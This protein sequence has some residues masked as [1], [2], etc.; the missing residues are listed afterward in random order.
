MTD[1][2]RF[3]LVCE[4]FEQV[5]A[6]DSDQQQQRRAAELCL[7]DEDLLAQVQQMLDA[8]RGS[9]PLDQPSHLLPLDALISTAHEHA[10]V[11]DRYIIGD[12]IGEGGMGVVYAAE[13]KSPARAVAI[14]V[15]KLG[16]DSERVIARF[17]L[18]RQALARMEHPNIASVVDAG[19]TDDGRPYFAMEL[20]RGETVTTYAAE[21]GL[22]T[23][24][25]L[26]LVIMVCNAIQHAHQKGIIHRDIKPSNIIVTQSDGS[27]I[28]KVIDF[29]IAKATQGD[30]SPEVSMTLHAQALGTPAYM[31]PEQ[32]DPSVG[33]ID[34]RTDV[35]SLGVVLYELLT[36]TTP[37]CRD[38]LTSKSY[39]ELVQSIREQDPPRPSNR[40]ATANQGNAS[41]MTKID[42]SELKGDLDWI[43]M[44]CLEKEPGRRYETIS[45]LGEDI[46]RYLRNKPVLARP[47]SSA[48]VVRKF[49]RR[50]RGGVVAASLILGTMLIG[51]AG[52]TVS[53]VWALDEQERAK[54]SAQAEL[55]AQTEAKEAAEVALSEAK[56]AEDLSQFFIMDVLSAADPSKTADR[57][58]TVR[59]ALVNASDNLE[60]KFEERPDVEGR[61]HNALGFLFGQ[62]GDPELAQ[63]HHMREWEI[64][65]A[66]NGEF[67]IES[68]RMMH[69][70]VGSLARQG[71]DSEAIEL[72]QRQLRVIDMLGTEEAELLRPRAIGNLGALLVRTG[73]NEEAAPILVDTLEIKRELY[74][75]RHPTTLSTLNNL[76]SVLASIGETEQSMLY[77]REAYE[78]RKQ[79]LGE[80]DPRTFVSLL[81]LARAIADSEMYDEALL[82]LQEGVSD[83]TKRLGADHPTTM[84]IINTYAKTLLDRGDYELSEQ[85][86][87]ANL[88]HL[89][90]ADPELNHARTMTAYTTLASTLRNQ[91]RP[92][93]ALA[94]TTTL[95]STLNE[96]GR[97]SY[98]LMSDFFRL[99]GQ[100]LMDLELFDQS[101]TALLRAWELLHS[102]ESHYANTEIVHGAIVEL[103]RRWYNAD[104]VP[105]IKDK[106]SH[107]SPD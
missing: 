99:H 21:H 24:S 65:E 91:S 9:S 44:K 12:R 94:Y 101:E 17:D 62:L 20:V 23:R 54:L 107:W 46:G 85:T 49:I 19:M 106:L 51:V 71:R 6:L 8:H 95:I 70:V 35:Y 38:E 90:A 83:A 15:I 86:I 53:L 67:S 105:E 5:R 58:L 77:G 82:M 47:A 2:E 74:G 60:G 11:I 76:C 64:A 40:L 43:V 96:S 3:E 57:D 42:P 55:K 56:A 22:D 50:N 26:E 1:A 4:I 66:E 97:E 33:D 27:L 30:L 14:K 81:N 75:D 98:H 63:K 72:T 103:Y 89:G 18:E 13:M 68:A 78:G 34:T 36:G 61:I 28:P 31:S 102:S 88:V 69:S 73:R 100:V 93:E 16:M 79:V 104:G 92:D 41:P 7:D 32:A 80:G 29:G 39:Q 25:R 87:R 52:T 59:E 45:A 48:Y 37:L 84:D 10:P